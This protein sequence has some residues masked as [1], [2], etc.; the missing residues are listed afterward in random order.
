MDELDAFLVR[1]SEESIAGIEKE[2]WRPLRKLTTSEQASWEYLEGLRR[3]VELARERVAAALTEERRSQ[4]RSRLDLTHDELELVSKLVLWMDRNRAAS[5]VFWSRLRFE[6]RHFEQLVLDRD[7][8]LLYGRGY[9]RPTQP[10]GIGEVSPM[11]LKRLQSLLG[12][13][14]PPEPQASGA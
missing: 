4:I 7:H 5:E 11:E 14:V 2:P 6:F 9:N 8:L 3:Q 10:E 1:I 12:E 13:G